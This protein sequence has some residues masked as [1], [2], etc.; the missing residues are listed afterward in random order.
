[1]AIEKGVT[2]MEKSYKFRI[3]PNEKQRVL[4]AKT[5]GCAR[6]VYNYYLDKKIKVYKETKQSISFYACCLDLTLLKKEAEWLKEVDKF[7]LQ[8]SLRNLDAAYQKFFKE[9]SGYPKFKSKHDNRKSYRTTFTNNNIEFKEGYIKL[10]KLGLVKFRDEQIPQGRILNATISQVPS[11]KYYCSICCTDVVMDDLPKTGC[12]LGIDLGLKD[13]LITSNGDK[14]SNPK[15]L[16]KSLNKLAKLQRALSR[17]PNGSNRK[18][19]ARIKVTRQYEKITNQ[20][21]DFL[22][23]LS[24]KLIQE[25]DIICLEDLQVENMVKNHKLARLINDVSWFE[26]RRQLEYKAK[27]YDKRVV[28]VDKFFPSSQICSCCGYVNKE[29]KDLKVRKWVCSECGTKHD[30]DINA[31]KNILNEGLRL[32]NC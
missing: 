5:F 2:S 7:S 20:R 14:V 25:N 3:Y 1:M 18:N 21:Q 10:P 22:K 11:G 13:F 4:M 31:A 32:L 9:H 17:K 29:T 19:K 23:K 8:N 12:V 16:S 15:Y 28:A 27:W 24:T 30:R 6:F 26:F